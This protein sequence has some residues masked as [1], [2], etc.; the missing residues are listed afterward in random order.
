MKR[1]SG[2]VLAAFS[3]IFLSGLPSQA[4]P[5]A[6][7]TPVSANETR[8]RATLNGLFAQY[9]DRQRTLVDKTLADVGDSDDAVLA[10]AETMEDIGDVFKDYYG[11]ADGGQIARLLKQ[12]VQMPG[13]YVEALREHE[14][15]TAITRVMREKGDEIAGLLNSFSPAWLDS[16]LSDLLKEYSDLM[17]DEIEMK[18][19]SF[20]KP[21]P[22]IFIETSE[23][24]A[25]MADAFSAGIV[26]QFPG[27]FPL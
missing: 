11:E 4:A 12:Y 9:L 17:V 18:D 8:L 20:G 1:H 10:L 14:D 19:D 5:G 16:G 6:I 23:T 13:D 25:E 7:K 3:V 15:T 22:D 27:K 21:D 26:K 2:A 24:C